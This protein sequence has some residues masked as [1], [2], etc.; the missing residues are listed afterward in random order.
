M[1][2]S[3]F[4]ASCRNGNVYVA[5]IRTSAAPQLLPSPVSS[6]ESSLWWMDASAGL[7]S[8]RIIRLSSSGQTVISDLRTPGAAVSWAQLDVQA[9]RCNLDDVKVSWAPVLDNCVAVSG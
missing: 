8:C 5:D 7:S 2:D 6:G 1:T 4:L 9:H 3:V